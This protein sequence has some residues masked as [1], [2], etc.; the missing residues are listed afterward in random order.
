MIL[1]KY[2]SFVM[3][4][5]RPLAAA[6]AMLAAAGDCATVRQNAWRHKG[7][8]ATAYITQSQV[9]VQVEAANVEYLRRV[10]ASTREWYTADETKAQLLLAV[11]GAFVT[12]L[13]GV[14]FSR[15]DDVRARADYFGLD[16][17]ILLER[18]S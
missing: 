7:R 14:L 10:Y 5:R 15:S 17:W 13:F 9:E 18:P 12:V 2:R 16:T 11:N 8:T 1:Q 4:T 3:L 6:S